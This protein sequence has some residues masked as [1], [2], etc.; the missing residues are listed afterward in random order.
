VDGWVCD[1][2][3]LPVRP[4]TSLIVFAIILVVLRRVTGIPISI[5]GSLVLT[6]IVTGIMHWIS[7]RNR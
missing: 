5:V 6:L 2:D 7:S 1:R 3:A 4:F